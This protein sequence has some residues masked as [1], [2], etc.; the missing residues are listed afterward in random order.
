LF[1]ERKA[2]HI[3]FSGGTVGPPPAEA[4]VMRDLAVALG[5][6][7]RRIVIEDEARNTF[8]NAVY[9]GHI[10]RERNWK[11]VVLVTD[12]YHLARAA[13]IFRRL[14]IAVE[15][16]AV[17]PDPGLTR[18]RRLR[19]HAAERLRLVRC[20]ALFALGAHKPLVGRVWGQ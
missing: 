7:P 6:D 20:A 14:G 13:F 16:V 5:L 2:G 8:E 11:R 1:F 19:Q 4:Y 10:I 15:A 18:A 9:A 12:C 17:P 3:I